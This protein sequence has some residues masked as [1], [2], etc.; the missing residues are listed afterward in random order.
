[1][2]G[3]GS[4]G[5]KEREKSCE[6]MAAETAIDSQGRLRSL[7]TVSGRGCSQEPLWKELRDTR[8]KA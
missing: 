5:G 4:N 2:Q 6:S 7:E 8:D 3:G 1:M